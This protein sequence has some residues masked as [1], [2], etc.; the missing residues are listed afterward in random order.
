MSFVAR[1]ILRLGGRVKTRAALHLLTLKAFRSYRRRELARDVGE[2][3]YLGA[4]RKVE[5]GVEYETRFRAWYVKM[6]IWVM[7]F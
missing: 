3:F 2:V 7:R 1:H 4:G 5:I 6:H